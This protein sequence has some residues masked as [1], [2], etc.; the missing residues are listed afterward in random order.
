MTSDDRIMTDQFNPTFSQLIVDWI[1]SLSPAQQIEKLKLMGVPH[2]RREQFIS[3]I[4]GVDHPV[5]TEA[6]IDL[7]PQT[8]AMPVIEITP[9]MAIE[10]ADFKNRPKPRPGSGNP[11][12]V[13][14]KRINP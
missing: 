7:L 9:T 5:V 6:P 3:A 8:G 10:G 2:D 1:S 4:S 13:P 11:K 12:L 14:S